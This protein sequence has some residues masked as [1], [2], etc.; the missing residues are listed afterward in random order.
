MLTGVGDHK[1]ICEHGRYRVTLPL[2]DGTDV[3]LEGICL[4]KVTGKFP[5]YPLKEAGDQIRQ[6]HAS[7]GGDVGNLPKLAKEVGGETDVMIGSLYLKY[8]PEQILKLPNGLTIYESHF[9][10]L[11]GSRG[12]VCGPHKSFAAIQLRLQGTHMTMSAYISDIVQA[13]NN[14]FRYFHSHSLPCLSPVSVVDSDDSSVAECEKESVVSLEK[15]G[16]ERDLVLPEVIVS[17]PMVARDVDDLCGLLCDD[18]EQVSELDSDSG[19]STSK[20]VADVPSHPSSVD[21]CDKD[22]VIDAAVV[23]S[24]NILMC[25][26]LVSL[27]MA[28]AFGFGAGFL[29][30]GNGPSISSN[31]SRF[32]AVDATSIPYRYTTFGRV[33]RVAAGTAAWSSMNA[34]HVV[35]LLSKRLGNTFSKFV[36]HAPSITR[37][38]NAIFMV[39]F[40]F[41]TSGQTFHVDMTSNPIENICEFKLYDPPF[42][43]AKGHVIATCENFVIFDYL[44]WKEE[45]DNVTFPVVHAA[46]L[47]VNVKWS[48]DYGY[49]ELGKD[50]EINHDYVACV[51]R[52]KESFKR[53]LHNSGLLLMQWEI[54]VKHL[55]RIKNWSPDANI[56]RNKNF[57]T[58]RYKAW[59]VS[60]VLPPDIQAK[61]FYFDKYKVG[62]IVLFCSLN[63]S[64]TIAWLRRFTR[65]GE[66]KIVCQSASENSNLSTSPGTKGLIVIPCINELSLT[67]EFNVISVNLLYN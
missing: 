30:S 33:G 57:L 46:S 63:R 1:S 9:A 40:S 22:S 11:D 50:V 47:H 41:S 52:V 35:W 58:D 65:L 3:K 13:Y 66:V 38:R 67:Q 25:T 17:E 54:M 26:F 62:D 37:H 2:H 27:L 24:V 14:S 49:G 18:P 15:V 44:S 48:S 5:K 8:H 34:K 10:N 59:L 45:N 32:F 56:M 61:W 12:V 21:Q 42:A 20:R 64:G 28:F 29:I 23:H 36:E 7:K 53:S 16:F 19:Y 55:A 60:C 51:G 39:L 4:D 6:F 43:C 31:G